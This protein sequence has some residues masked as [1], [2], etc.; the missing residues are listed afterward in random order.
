M[1]GC[2]G[3]RATEVGHL[4]A[5]TSGLFR[6]GLT[7]LAWMAS[8]VQGSRCRVG[9][10]QAARRRT[11]APPRRSYQRLG[12]SERSGEYERPCARILVDNFQASQS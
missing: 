10:H 9:F 3:K 2:A 8:T 6:P 5:T 7:P 12:S 11:D 1:I 4:T